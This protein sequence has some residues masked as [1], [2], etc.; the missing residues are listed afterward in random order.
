MVMTFTE[1]VAFDSPAIIHNFFDVTDGRLP[2]ICS[3]A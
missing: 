1:T 2:G 3:V